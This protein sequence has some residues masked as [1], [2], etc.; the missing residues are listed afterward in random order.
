M[1]DERTPFA[2]LGIPPALEARL[3]P[4]APGQALSAMARG[5]LPMAPDVQLAVLYVLATRDDEALRETCFET[6]NKLPKKLLIDHIGLKTHPK[7][8]ELVATFR[9]AHMAVE[10]AIAFSKMDQGTYRTL[11]HRWV[12]DG[13]EVTTIIN[14]NVITA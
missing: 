1:S 8:V 13:I 11:D 5:L 6:L 4:D 7:V 9:Y 10:A 2:R 12:D 3:G 14:G